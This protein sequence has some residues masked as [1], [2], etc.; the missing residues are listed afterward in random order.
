MIDSC[1]SQVTTG[2]ESD[3]KRPCL[4]SHEAMSCG[5]KF[6]PERI[7]LRMASGDSV[8][9]PRSLMDGSSLVNGNEVDK[10]AV[11]EGCGDGH[12]RA[13]RATV[14]IVLSG[15]LDATSA[16]SDSCLEFLNDYHLCALA[17]LRRP[18]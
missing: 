9:N 7:N 2:V 17:T 16:Q 5:F 11:R 10:M 12:F 6:W 13:V 18:R 8:I 3:S 15:A 14:A 1:R 4:V